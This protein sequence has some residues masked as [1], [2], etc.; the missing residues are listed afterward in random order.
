MLTALALLSAAGCGGDGRVPL[1][2][3]R[4]K[5]TAALSA[6]TISPADRDPRNIRA[7]YRIPGENYCDQ[8]YV[9]VTKDGNWLCTLTTGR[10]R[11][12]DKGQHVVATISTDKGRTWSRP[13]DI[14]P[15]NGPE[16]SWVVPLVTPGGRVYAFYDY[17]GDRIER[18]GS[19]APAEAGQRKIRADTI[20]WYCYRY[21]D[22]GGRTWSPQRRRLP[23][24][25]TACDRG[26]DWK[27]QVQIFWGI[28]KPI[29]VG[30]SAYFA[31]TKLG[32][33]M[34]ERGEGWL[35][36]SDNVLT[37]T[38]VSKIRWELLPEGDRGIRAEE[39]GSVQEEHNIVALSDGSLLCVYRTTMGYPC[40][41][42]SRDGGRTWSRPRPM[43]YTPG[44]RTFRHPR[45]CPRVWKTTSG[46]FLFWFHN[47][48][49]RSW[50]GRNPAWI[51][52]G[53][54]KDG[55]IHWSQPEVVLYDPRPA[56]RISYP[57]LIE[58]DGR[59]W[60]TETQKT[61]ARVHEIDRTLLEGLWSQGE[62]RKVARRGLIVSAGPRELKAGDLA[63][64]KR[65]DLRNTGGVSLDFWIALD[66]PAAGQI[67]ADCRDE[68]GAGIVLIT[69][70]G[71]G[72][73][74]EISDGKATA[75]W[76]CGARL[77]A[78]RV[79]HVAAIV[80]A[81]PKIISFVV[82]GVLW[83][84]GEKRQYGWGRYKP[85]L[86]DVTGRGKLRI[87]PSLKAALKRLR[88]YD[89]YLRTS[90]VVANFHAGPDA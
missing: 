33:Y 20:G 65:L 82:D 37:E 81:G 30:R 50:A 27:G 56:M 24:R 80:D 14:E 60:V 49:G 76:S 4:A 6:I 22:D 90:E 26:N 75:G 48:G 23:M 46:R 47:N 13:I 87:A 78:G 36:R 19:T 1:S 55:S 38:D 45:A 8:P 70:K 41:A 15:A 7:G 18:L 53:I 79:H 83:D 74:I 31:F 69:T 64:P 29:V 28:C 16:A 52:G 62:V 73:R 84:G 86:G 12:G 35:Y 77:A 10:G 11:E 68:R 9:V 67:I 42:T 72:L 63:L 43:T 39:F 58:Q 5:E 3:H 59:Y 32:R 66:D 51:S 21:S 61:V 34:L 57:D 17:N 85:D 71:G 40:C 54:E 88:V 44:G 2:R 89:R 25:L